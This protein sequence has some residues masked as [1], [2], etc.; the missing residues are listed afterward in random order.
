MWERAAALEWWLRAYGKTPAE[1]RAMPAWFV[2]RVPAIAALRHE[3][4]DEQREKGS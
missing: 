1:V 3:V 4:L 2:T